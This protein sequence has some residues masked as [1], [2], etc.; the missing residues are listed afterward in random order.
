[1]E[2]VGL[3]FCV[4]FDYTVEYTGLAVAEFVLTAIDF[5]Y[6]FWL[7]L[8]SQPTLPLHRNL[9]SPRLGRVFDPAFALLVLAR[10]LACA[11][12]RRQKNVV[13]AP[14]ISEEGY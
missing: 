8:S 11:N 4:R 14:S 13:P 5:V 9:G 1:M 3:L 10:R 2:A 6:Q 7:H 12:A